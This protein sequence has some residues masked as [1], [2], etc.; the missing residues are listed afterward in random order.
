MAMVTV[1][2]HVRTTYFRFFVLL[3]AVGLFCVAN[4]AQATEISSVDVVD[5]TATSSTISWETDIEADGTINYGLTPNL[6]I[7]RYPY[8]DETEHSLTLTDL[9]PST[10]YYFRITSS[11]VDGN[12]SAASGYTFTTSNAQSTAST[13]KIVDSEEKAITERIISELDKVA[14]PEA[15]V[16]IAEKVEQV[17]QDILKPPAIVGKPNVVVEENTA[18]IS[19]TTDRKSNSFVHL[20]TDEE[21]GGTSD[22]Y[23]VHQGDPDE[24]VLAHVIEVIGL[25]PSTLYHFSVSSEDS[26]GLRGETE[27]N[28]FRTKSILPE[29]RNITVSRVQETSAVVSWTTGGVL[30]KG[31]VEFTNTRTNATR[32]SGNPIYATTHSVL[33]ADL[34]FGTRYSAVIISTNQDGEQVE[35]LPFTFVTVRDI[36]DPEISKVNNESTLFP[37][38]DTKIQTII[39]WETDEPATCQV[40]YGQGVI[41]GEDEEGEAL[42]PE[43]NP[44]REHTQV[45][46]G[47]APAT[48]YK[49]WM[50]CRDVAQNEARSEDFVLITPIKEKNIIDIILENFQGT[51]GWI[52]N[53]GG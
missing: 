29:I 17:A 25:E 13:A 21:Y 47:F 15:I 49:F 36:V 45:V 11:D 30:A 40:F 33:L 48:V 16:A 28:T 46:V 22:S 9:L 27:D 43:L 14:T 8:F 42:P 34:E 35:S 51:F 52:N 26:L 10:T 12:R 3:A 7:A 4:T 1:P 19:W 31:V 37:G 20:V 24:Q 44:L 38:E 39:S 6:G 18:T 41:L 23:N 50:R 53:I 2:M 32:S 5:V